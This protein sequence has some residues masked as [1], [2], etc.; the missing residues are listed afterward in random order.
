MGKRINQNTGKWE[1]VEDATIETNAPSRVA[2]FIPDL[3]D[4]ALRTLA[5]EKLSEALQAIDPREQPELTRKLCAEVKDRLDGKPG[6]QITM[7]ATLKTVNVI[8]NISFIPASRE[9]LLID[10]VDKPQLIEV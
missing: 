10:H 6:Q 4:D 2:A 7:D 1:D 3:S 8:A 9:N 5:R